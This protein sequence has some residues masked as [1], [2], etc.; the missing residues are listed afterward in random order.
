[1]LI[2]LHWSRHKLLIQGPAALVESVGAVSAV[3]E[4]RALSNHRPEIMRPSLPSTPGLPAAPLTGHHHHHNQNLN[5]H[6]NHHH[7]YHYL[8][9]HHNH[10]HHPH[11]PSGDN[12]AITSLYTRAACCTSNWPLHAITT[13]TFTTTFTTTTIITTTHSRDCNT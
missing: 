12:V 11:T 1:M 8:H 9:H 2:S 4:S 5:H 6:H 7:Q 10:H 3:G 13:T